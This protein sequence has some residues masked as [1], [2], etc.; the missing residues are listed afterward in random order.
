MTENHHVTPSDV[1][2]LRIYLTPRDKVRG[3]RRFA[4]LGDRPLYRE[5]VLLAKNAGIVNAVAH[6]ARYGFGNPHLTVCVELVSQRSNL[7]AFCCRNGA[8]LRGKAIAF[9]H[10]EQW[11]VGGDG[12]PIQGAA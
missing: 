4:F 11:T 2:M 10:M 3:S 7:E 8:L 5:L 9:T 1:G 6:Q 12:E